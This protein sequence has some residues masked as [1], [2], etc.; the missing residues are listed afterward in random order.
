VDLTEEERA[1]LRALR[2]ATGR[3]QAVSSSPHSRLESRTLSA[4]PRGI[5]KREGNAPGER[6]KPQ[7][8]SSHQARKILI[9]CLDGPELERHLPRTID[10]P[11][12]DLPPPPVKREQTRYDGP[13][14]W[15]EGEILLFHDTLSA[16]DRA[17]RFIRTLQGHDP[18]SIAATCCSGECNKWLEYVALDLLTDPPRAAERTARA[19]SAFY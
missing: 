13:D 4:R 11:M 9:Q 17:I 7:S 16:T 14:V 5:G 15:C 18:A 12:Q 3:G 1:R 19:H 2:G 6:R 8:A 10:L